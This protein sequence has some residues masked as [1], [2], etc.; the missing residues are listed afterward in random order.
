MG[1]IRQLANQT[2]WYGLSNILGRFISYLLTPLLTYTFDSELFG[3]ISIIFATAAFLNILFTFG[4]ETSYFRFT[5]QNEEKQIFNTTFT[6]IL[7]GTATLTALLT[8]FSGTLSAWLSMENHQELVVLMIGIVAV[9]ALCVIPFSRLRKQGRSAKFAIIKLLNI[10]INVGLLFLVLKAA[11]PAHDAGSP[12]WT[13]SLYDPSVG[14]GYVFITQLIASTVTFLLLFKEWRSFRVQID[15]ALMGSILTYAAPL[16][17]V[18][19]GG[20]INET[21]DRIM[22]VRFFNGTGQEAKIANG[23]YSANYKLAIL[24]TIFVQ[25]FRMGAEPF[26]FNNAGKEDEKRTNARIMNFFVIGCCLCFLAVTLYLDIWKY[27]MGISKD[28][29][30]EEGLVVVPILMMANVFLGIYYNLSIWY[31]L[32]DRNR[33]GAWITL[34]GVVITLLVNYLLIP[35]WGYIACAWATLACY[36]AMMLISYGLGRKFYPI[37]YHWKKTVFYLAT[38]AA[39]FFVHDAIRKSGWPAGEL[40]VTGSLFLLFFAWL[41]LMLEKQEFKKIP[42]LKRI[43]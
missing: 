22:I 30:Y 9:D 29:R 28:P 31:K 26:F 12:S 23:I 34:I 24:I 20:M 18:G 8:L 2:I 3:E 37:P 1:G 15:G 43:Y 40:H 42:L 41:V 16:I 11:K 10:L 39:L 19:L 38:S 4:M 32:T 7:V 25:T 6:A 27:F 33:M 13:A 35:E 14:I 17:I 36:G 5:Q 21:F